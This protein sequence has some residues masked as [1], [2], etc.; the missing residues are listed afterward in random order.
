VDTSWRKFLRVEAEG[1]LACDFL[2]VDRV[3]LR[4]LYV[5]FMVEVAILFVPKSSS[6]VLTST[7]EESPA[8]SR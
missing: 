4:R 2:T 8:R 7:D 6:T 5:L 1:L 3:L